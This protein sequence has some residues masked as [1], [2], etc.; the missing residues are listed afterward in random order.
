M[1]RRLSL[2]RITLA[3]PFVACLSLALVLTGRVEA[4]DGKSYDPLAIP[5]EF[6]P[7]T[8]DMTV[9]DDS[10]NREIPIR[11]YLPKGDSHAVLLFSHG[12]GGSREGSAFLGKHWSARGYSVVFVQ[13]P[14][15]DESVWR[16]QPLAKRMSAM[17]EAASLKNF[18]LRAQDIPAVLDQLAK[19]NQEKGHRL[20]GKVNVERVGM[21]GHSFGGHTTQ[22]VSGQNFPAGGQRLTDARVKAA[23]VM[24]PSSPE[25]G[26]V[27][28]AFGKVA[29]PWLLMTGTH[30]TASIGGQTVESRRKVYPALPPGHKYELVLENAEHSVFTDRALP[31]DQ[32]QRDPNHHRAILA[33]STA[34]WDAYLRNDQAAQ[35]WLDKSARTVLDAKDVW[36]SK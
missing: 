10:R 18:M 14:G 27:E 22:A 2:G 35:E 7:Q 26:D 36:Q 11:V 23:I 13:H 24:S 31:G 20:N 5:A 25:R 19:W 29:I 8:V 17:R 16:G 9:K 15:S 12:L 32:K 4:A 33:L 1:P 34:F 3:A 30:D 28:T 6:Q 21:S